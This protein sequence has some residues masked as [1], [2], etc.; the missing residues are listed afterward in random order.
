M[1][2]PYPRSYSPA[3]V[4]AILANALAQPNHDHLSWAD[5]QA[6]AADM[7]IAPDQLQRAEAAWV[8]QEQVQEQQRQRRQRR[9]QEFAL[10]VGVNAGLIGLNV[11]TAGGITW[12]IYPLLGWGL[13]LLWP[14]GCRARTGQ[15]TPATVGQHGRCW[16]R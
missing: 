13:G 7:A 10:Y 4:Q 1:T 9:R 2:S 11:A 6:I 5:L 3:A 16:S 12:A 14:G 8:Q 15:S